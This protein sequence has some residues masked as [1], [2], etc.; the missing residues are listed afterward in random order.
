MSKVY[1]ELVQAKLDANDVP[2]TSKT[3]KTRK[4]SKTR[5]HRAKNKPAGKPL[6]A[7]E[8]L[9]T[10]DPPLKLNIGGGDP[11]SER[12]VERPGYKLV[13]RH[14]G[15]EAYPLD[16]PD[17]CADE[18]LA[19]HVLEHFPYEK[20]PDVL[21]DWVRVL[22]PGGV[23][24][25]AVPDLEWICNEY[26]KQSNVPLLGY[27]MGGHTDENDFHKAIFDK[28]S[29]KE[30]LAHVGL[31]RLGKWKSDVADS[32]SM[33]VSCNYLGYKP[34]G[35][36]ETLENVHAVLATPRFGPVMHFKCIL[37]SFTRLRLRCNII[38]GCF[39][40]MQLCECM[41]EA[42]VAGAEYVLTLDYDSIFTIDDVM[43]LYHLLQVYPEADAVCALQ[44]KRGD[45]T[46]LIGMS[47]EERLIANNMTFA[48]N[49][50]Q[51]VTGHFGCT[52][53]RA[54]KL[55]QLP[56]PWMVAKPSSDGSWAKGSGCI[57]PDIQFWHDWSAANK[58]LYV[59]NK[60][61]IGHME[62]KITWPSQNFMPMYQSLEEYMKT[63]KPAEV[64]R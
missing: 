19:S 10:D 39:W 21:R 38:Q 24:K 40:Y 28:D 1:A 29:I 25:I 52:M 64:K 48:R 37:D 14:V 43:E 15:T 54:N 16:F 56:R 50:T 34:S 51:V 44:S 60:V 9:G 45:D 49:L 2:P 46:V 13:D 22:K 42:I 6:S 61:V 26:I 33:P 4:T 12:Y 36:V 20:V 57:H 3:K 31:Q 59:A 11:K 7:D 18:I 62:E 41:E 58:T 32:A 63:G 30:M 27:I 47:E 55:N 23:L 17:E 53:F 5:K 35:P 8:I